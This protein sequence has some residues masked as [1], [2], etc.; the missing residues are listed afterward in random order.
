M[1]LAIVGIHQLLDQ[2]QADTGARNRFTAIIAPVE[3][4][5]YGLLLF[6]SDAHTR[7]A[8]RQ[9]DPVIFVQNRANGDPPTC[10]CIF[11]GIGQ[12]IQ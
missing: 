1:D 2:G 7:V 4:L 6:L 10:W 8:D 3:S 12:E 11:N 9:F 5:K